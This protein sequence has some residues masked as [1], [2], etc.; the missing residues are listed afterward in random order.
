MGMKRLFIL[1]FSALF[2]FGCLPLFGC[3]QQADAQ[4]PRY[5]ITAEYHEESRTLDAIC[6]VTYINGTDNT[7]T[8][9]Q[10]NVY[11]NAYRQGAQFAPVEKTHQ[12]DAY[13]AGESYGGVQ[14]NGVTGGEWQW[15]GQDNTLL[16]VQLAQPL[17]PD[18]R[19]TVTVDYTLTLAQ[20]SHRTGV[21]ERAVNLGN[22]YPVLCPYDKQGFTECPYYCVGD[23]FVSDCADYTVCLTLPHEYVCAAS[24]TLTSANTQNGKTTHNFTLK[25]ARDFAVVLSKEFQTATQTVN[26]AAV[27]YY[28][29]EDDN[30]QATLD[31]ACQSLAFFGET[32]GAYA[33]PT[34]AVVQTGFCYAGME[35]P[36]LVMLS[37]DK[38]TQEDYYT[39]VHEVAHQWW[40]AAVGSDQTN[41]SWQDE[42]LTEY[43]TLLFFEAHPAYG[44]TRAGL[45]GGATK[46]YRAY[47]SVYN[48]IFGDTDTAMSRSLSAFSG[49]YEYVN[50]A[51]RKGLL[52]FDA[53]REFLGDK[54]FISAL[55]KYYAAFS[56]QTATAGDIASVFARYGDTDG[57]FNA[58][59]QGNIVI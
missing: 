23:P 31:V 19:V 42:G 55:K 8:D 56:F 24:G 46:A 36:A 25:G 58:F 51:Y 16:C 50:I 5:F 3:S 47:F 4:R 38:K 15:G 28:Y 12:L 52:L 17:Y 10:F 2:L 49:E 53:L 7:L 27:T 11:G 32:F 1:C 41:E 20:V 54:K 45:I 37:D 39:T 21:T 35:Y 30:P 59:L 34:L 57:I 18:E 33:Y 40:Y 9:L 43:S 6:A 44:Y 14:I 22:F 26:G 13:Y 48:Q 29:Y